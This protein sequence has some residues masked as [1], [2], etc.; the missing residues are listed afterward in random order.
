MNIRYTL[1]EANQVLKLVRVIAHEMLERRNDRRQLARRRDQLESAQTPEGLRSE[2]SELDA[3]IWEHDEALYNCKHELE[4]LGLTV[5]RTNPLTV[6]IPGKNTKAKGRK[7]VSARA[8]ATPNQEV[9]FCWQEGED[10]VGFGH[11]LGEEE[12]QR[13][14]LRV[15]KGA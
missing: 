14:P 13:R 2:L 3:R 15:A 9:V 8:T 6:H 5:L 4:D 12:H 10:D 1:K 11:P 7:K